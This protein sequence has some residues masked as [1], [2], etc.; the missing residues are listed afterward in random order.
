MTLNRREF[1]KLA[2][3]AGCL[4]PFAG[5]SSLAHGALKPGKPLLLTLFLR[6]GADGLHLV[7]PAADPD[8]VAVRPPEMRVAEGGERAGSLLE[9]SLD[10]ALGFRLH[11]E[12]APLFELYQAQRMAIVHAVGLTDGTRSHFVA[13]DLIERGIGT[14]KAMA[15]ID[16]GWLARSLVGAKGL[17]PG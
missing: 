1:I 11:P 7:A 13:Q 3:A 5:I 17:V 4:S 2:T 8:Y 14:E 9:R 12:A 15:N 10:P 16:S 6:G